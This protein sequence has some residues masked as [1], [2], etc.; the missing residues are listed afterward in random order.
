[1][2]NFGEIKWVEQRAKEV[3]D[4]FRKVYEQGSASVKISASVGIATTDNS[5]N[6]EDIYRFA[7]IA[8]YRTK[9]KGKDGYSFYNGE[10]LTAY[11]SDRTAIE[12]TQKPTA[13][14]V[15]SIA[16]FQKDLKEYVFD[17]AT[18]TSV[19]KNTVELILEMIR[20]QFQF[21]KAYITK[22]NFEDAEVRCIYDWVSVDANVNPTV[23]VLTIQELTRMYSLFRS[24]RILVQP[25]KKHEH[26]FSLQQDISNSLWVFPL[27][28]QKGLLGCIGFEKESDESIDNVKLVQNIED[29]CRQL[30]TV[31]VNQFLIEGA[32]KNYDN[33]VTVLDCLDEPVYVTRPDAAMPLF[34]NKAAKEQGILYHG[35]KCGKQHKDGSACFD[36]PLQRAVE[37]GGYFEDEEYIIQEVSW[38]NGASVYVVRIKPF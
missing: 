31:V 21:S 26:I 18:G 15:E 20:N 10:E 13:D 29:V 30:S 22:I 1:M 16:S 27:M 36:C 7:D 17:L 35:E 8:L 9:T 37:Q 19:A 23:K 24:G 5:F 4:E 3:C 32:V 33:M 2:R 34:A 11:Q 12:S 6:Y 28:S 38:G 25:A 14:P